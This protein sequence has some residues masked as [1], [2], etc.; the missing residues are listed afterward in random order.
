MGSR[1]RSILAFRTYTLPVE[2]EDGPGSG[3]QVW[4]DFLSL[5]LI[6]IKVVGCELTHIINTHPPQPCSRELVIVRACPSALLTN[7]SCSL[8]S[9]NDLILLPRNQSPHEPPNLSSIQWEEDWYKAHFR[10][11]RHTSLF[12]WSQVEVLAF[13]A[14]YQ[15]QHW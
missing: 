2:G 6:I 14:A 13:W 12:G 9:C 11:A 8:R 5:G 4:L 10:T 15:L 7:I 3:S 1:P